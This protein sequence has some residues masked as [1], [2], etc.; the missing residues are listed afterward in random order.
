MKV[1]DIATALDQ[2]APPQLAAEWD[3][4]GLLIGEPDKTVRK[5]MLCIDLTPEV[6]AEARAVK[7]Q[8][9]MAYHPPIFKPV[10]RVRADLQPAVYEAVRAG[11]AVYSMHTALDAAP[12]G[13]NDVLAEAV[14]IAAP[15]PLEPR[16]LPGMCKVVVFAPPDDLSAIADA[17]FAAGAGRIG[18][19]YDCA[20][21]CHGI[22]VFCGEPS[23]RPSLGKPGRHEAI[24]EMRLETVAPRR[25]APA[26]VAAVQAAHSYETPRID[27]LPLEQYPPGC[28][29][30]RVGELAKPVTASALISRIKK[31]LG[32]PKVQVAGGPKGKAA[33]PKVKIVACAAGSAGGLFRSAVAA[34]ATLYVTGEMRHHD[35][36][37]ARQAGL[38]VVCVGHSNS[39][40]IALA[41]LATRLE[42][43]CGKLSV[44][45]SKKDIDPFAV[46]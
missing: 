39:E 31:A 27:V 21:F 10:E 44:A 20:F 41:K 29:M 11:V 42:K 12:G 28:G 40:R 32:V 30:G 8:M 3:N 23:A 9:V 43:L 24:E 35:A 1:R 4:V 37:A 19:Y 17:A 13:T 26:V 18:N 46:I 16:D 2:I 25:L 14:G 38:T 22:G 5:L 33:G 34:G 45:V 36:L 6:L 15:K 7:A